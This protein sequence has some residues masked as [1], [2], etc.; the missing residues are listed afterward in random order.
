MTRD[1]HDSI[2]TDKTSFEQWPSNSTELLTRSPF[3]HDEQISHVEQWS[4]FIPDNQTFNQ[5]K[6]EQT[7]QYQSYEY[8]M[9][10]TDARTSST[11]MFINRSELIDK[12]FDVTQL[13]RP[14]RKFLPD[15]SKQYASSITQVFM[16]TDV[17]LLDQTNLQ[18]NQ[19]QLAHPSEVF[20]YELPA[21]SKL[22][23]AHLQSNPSV[24]ASDTDYDQSLVTSIE[25][26]QQTKGYKAQ[27]P[28]TISGRTI[29]FAEDEFDTIPYEVRIQQQRLLQ[30]PIESCDPT[31]LSS[32]ETLLNQEDT[33]KEIDASA[34]MDS[35]VIEATRAQH[36]V[37][38]Y[39]EQFASVN[40]IPVDSNPTLSA[41]LPTDI[42]STC[43]EIVQSETITSNQLTPQDVPRPAE[44]QSIPNRLDQISSI[45]LMPQDVSNTEEVQNNATFMSQSTIA[46][47]QMAEHSNE[48]HT[49]E[50][51]HSI[52]IHATRGELDQKQHETI[53]PPSRIHTNEDSHTY[54]C[55]YILADRSEHLQTTFISNF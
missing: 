6:P 21:H 42:S 16:A 24:L 52:G 28:T 40:S 22:S 41:S 35:N 27:R 48:I 11:S 4:D 15:E 14:T 26:Y 18:I 54:H 9:P 30:L 47:V 37:H 1:M 5:F 23:T 12:P 3:T 17:P 8:M 31:I 25:T 38:D 2:G 49:D 10:T 32:N 20:Q 53:L 13:P 36:D 39:P 34:I 29:A 44:I 51:M 7:E 55:T 19:I 50:Q 33:T 45:Q 43:N 46:S